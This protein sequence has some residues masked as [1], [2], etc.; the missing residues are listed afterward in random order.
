MS[1]LGGCKLDGTSLEV[2]TWRFKIAQKGAIKKDIVVAKSINSLK[3]ELKEE[4]II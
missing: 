1:H 3:L 2:I 4:I